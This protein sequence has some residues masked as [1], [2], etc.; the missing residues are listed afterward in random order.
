MTEVH[1]DEND[2]FLFENEMTDAYIRAS[3]QP[4]RD[5]AL[6]HVPASRPPNSQIA[7]IVPSHS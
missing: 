2:R 4:E 1:A 3:V 6:G 7:G 5:P